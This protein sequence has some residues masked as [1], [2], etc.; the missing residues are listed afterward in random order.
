MIGELPSNIE[1]LHVTALLQEGIVPGL[2]GDFAPA[3]DGILAA[4]YA[5]RERLLP[6]SDPSECAPINIPIQR[7]PCGR[8]YLCSSGVCHVLERQDP[9]PHKHRRA[10]CTEYARLGN[11]DIKSVLQTGGADKSYRVPYEYALLQD[12]MI[13]WWCS[14]DADMIRELLVEVTSLG[15]FRGAGKGRV[16]EWIVETCEPRGDGF[17]VLRDGQAMRPLPLDYPGLAAKQQIAYRTLCPPYHL[18]MLEQ[19]CVVPG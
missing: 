9:T 7:S 2:S 4:V 13:E 6:P 10:P 12:N 19:P 8:F 11:A 5:R 16:C 14:G 18:R 1:P 3:L 17:P 15:K